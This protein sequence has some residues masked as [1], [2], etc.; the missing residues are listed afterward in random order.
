MHHAPFAN[1]MVTLSPS[2]T[3]V[4]SVN[5]VALFG[6]TTTG[7]ASGSFTMITLISPC[8]ASGRN[9]A[10]AVAEEISIT[11]L[12]EAKSPSDI[13]LIFRLFTYNELQY[14]VVLP[15]LYVSVFAGSRLLEILLLSARVPPVLPRLMTSPF[16]TRVPFTYKSLFI[17]APPL[18]V[19]AE[20]GLVISMLLK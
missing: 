11:V 7:A 15:K 13:L 3:N 20:S 1:N 5:P 2:V 12:D 16:T 8:I 19:K 17:N 6:V 9:I 4:I 18:T 10:G 14:L